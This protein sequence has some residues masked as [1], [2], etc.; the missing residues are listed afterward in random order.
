[1]RFS[2][3]GG[4]CWPTPATRD[5][6]LVHPDPLTSPGA[7]LPGRAASGRRMSNSLAPGVEGG[8]ASGLV[9]PEQFVGILKLGTPPVVP[10]APV[11]AE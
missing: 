7:W 4:L 10:H 6:R 3:M 9:P 8:A 1:M 11:E 2:D 5:P